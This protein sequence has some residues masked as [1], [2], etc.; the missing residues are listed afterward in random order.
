MEK[1]NIRFEEASSEAKD[2][3]YSNTV[4]DLKTSDVGKWY[5]MVFK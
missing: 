2:N 5:S 4:E 3:Y 1:S